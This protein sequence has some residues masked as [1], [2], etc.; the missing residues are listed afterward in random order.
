[1]EIGKE[2]EVIFKEKQRK[3]KSNKINNT[4]T[5]CFL[6]TDRSAPYSSSAA[7]Q[8]IMQMKV[9]HSEKKIN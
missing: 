7:K 2:V 3:K 5:E 4:L 6:R 8:N 1:L 9:Y